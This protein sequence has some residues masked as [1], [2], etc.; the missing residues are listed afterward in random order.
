MLRVSTIFALGL[1]AGCAS[2]DPPMTGDHSTVK[3]QTDLQRCRK[4]ASGI[5]TRAANATPQSAIKALFAS[6]DPE[7]KTVQTCM[8][9]R[10]YKLNS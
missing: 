3:Y 5:A 8:Q 2:Y 4:E 6:D 9:S 10:G 7:R 1:L